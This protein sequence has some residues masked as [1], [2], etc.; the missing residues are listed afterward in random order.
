MPSNPDAIFKQLP[1][2]PMANFLYFIGD[3]AA[4]EIAIVDPAWDAPYLIREADKAGHKIVAVLLTHGHPDHVNGL[5]DL[6]EHR[7][8]PVYISAHEADYYTPACKSL[9]KVNDGDKIKIGNIDILCL[10]T[11][12]HSPGCQCFKIGDILIAGDAIFIDGCGRCD[13]PGG[14]ARVMYNS[15]YNIIAKLPDSTV[16]YPGH[17]YGSVPF[18]TVKEQKRTNPYLQ[19]KSQDEFL[20]QRMGLIA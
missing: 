9:R 3:A 17:D 4:K 13:L 10:H 16:I 5:D 20:R 1:L 7:D 8:I 6:L 2:G 19:C 14:D 15:L 11:P 18:A 12:G